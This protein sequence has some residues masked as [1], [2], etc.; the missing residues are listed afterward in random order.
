MKVLHINV[1]YTSN[2]LHSNMI[3]EL[4]R[5]G[6]KCDVF[7]PVSV[8]DNYENQKT[9]VVVSKCYNKYDRINFGVKQRKIYSSLVK[10]M[11]IKEYNYVHAYTV[12]TDGNVAFE[13]NKRFGIP[14]VVAV[15]NSD[16][17]T[18]FKYMPHLRKRGVEIMK[19]ATAVFFLS[20]KYKKRTF[21]EYIPKKF[22][23][24]IEKKT[25]VIPNGIDNFWLETPRSVTE[26]NDNALNV[27]CAG[28][29]NKNKNMIS[30]IKALQL[31]QQQGKKVHL[32]IAGKVENQKIISE[33]MTYGFVTYHGKL[34]K[35]QLC[36][37]YKKNDVFALVSF[38]ETFGMVY[39]E[40]MSRGLPVI[41]TKNEG[42]DGQFPEGE[43]GFAVDPH[44][45]V[46]IAEKIK[47]AYENRKRISE[48]CIRAVHNYGW[49]KIVNK[50]IEIYKS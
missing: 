15:R 25:Y 24:E 7:V 42:F 37:L 11:P 8:N 46:Q 33:L 50:Y 44:N 41:Y 23:E 1:H 9:N 34:T 10:L 13:L 2:V 6:I 20:K 21:D 49:K 35:E 3:A 47:E 19:N 5:Q 32:D 26:K 45:V 39:I 22:A 48:N 30:L 17:N 36:E 31:L 14:Y 43:V 16:V 27:M 40:A 12:F 38:H 29:I 4:E 28:V 18:F